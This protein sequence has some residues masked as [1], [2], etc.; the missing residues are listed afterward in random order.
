MKA[1]A[2]DAK[3]DNNEEDIILLAILIYLL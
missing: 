1:K 2:F 3:F